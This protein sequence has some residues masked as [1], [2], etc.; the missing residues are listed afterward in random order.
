MGAGGVS[1]RGGAAGTKRGTSGALVSLT[2]T[3]LSPI[4][5]VR[6]SGLKPGR[7]DGELVLAGGVGVGAL[8]EDVARRAATEL[9]AVFLDAGAVGVRVD[10]NLDMAT[11]GAALC[12]GAAEAVGVACWTTVCAPGADGVRDADGCV[13][14]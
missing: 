10:A 14:M 5:T 6:A 12:T 2:R 13:A 11:A 9:D 1:A 7:R 3:G 4:F 8:V